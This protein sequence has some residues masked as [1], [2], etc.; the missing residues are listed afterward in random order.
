[1][2]ASEPPISALCEFYPALINM[3]TWRQN[4]PWRCEP[5]Y[6]IPDSPQ[7]RLAAKAA[8]WFCA[9][10]RSDLPGP[11]HSGSLELAAASVDG[12]QYVWLQRVW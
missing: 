4:C 3:A 6:R 1:M 11:E 8:A 7:E 5:G 12:S 2:K 9:L 10:A